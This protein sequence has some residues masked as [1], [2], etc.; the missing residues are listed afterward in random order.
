[1]KNII[2]AVEKHK[3]LILETERYIWKNP[4]TG[5]KEVKTTKYLAD[6]FEKLGYEITFADGITGFY[7]VF[8]TG[9][10]GPEI[11][12][13]AE[14]DSVICPAHPEADKETGA[15]HSCG[16]NTEPA[17]LIGI[18]AA[19]KDVAVS[20]KLCGRVK[21]CAVP[22]EELLEI[23]F[24]QQL[25]EEGKIRYLGGKPEFL[26]RG[27]FDSS[28]IAIVVHAS[29]HAHTSVGAVGCIVKEVVYKGKA[30][31]AGGAPWDGRNALYAATCG[32]GAVNAIRETFR[33]DDIIRVH[34]IITNGGAMVNAIPE[35]VRLESY[36]R[37]ASFEG[38]RDANERVNRA[39]CGAALSMGAN[40]EI[41]DTCGYAPL[42]DDENLI[43]IAQTAAKEVLPD[44]TFA[45]SEKPW[46]A[47]TDMG[48]L[49]CV[50]P[51]V[52]VFAGGATGTPHGKD[53]QIEDPVSAC[54]DSAKLQLAIIDILLRDNGREAK[55]VIEEFKPQ[56]DGK[57]AYFE[58]VD[59]ISSSGDRI[60]YTESGAKVKL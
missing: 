60:E 30:S 5:Y 35:K 55:R 26:H 24:R 37:G 8:D 4:E 29:T 15:V 46:S 41:V 31:H 14:L 12:V 57:D 10:E 54:V 36:V 13:L 49:S 23:E 17:A 11:L 44:K 18:A 3:D 7:T 51:S 59:S 33:E 27:Y 52:H 34:P 21:L 6:A 50:M 16:H 25:K 9:R 28:D 38:M 47:S 40:V 45:H 20:E 58:Y 19:L 56:F 1:M 32:I 43:E 22:A 2:S 53:Y 39:L 48:D 42:S